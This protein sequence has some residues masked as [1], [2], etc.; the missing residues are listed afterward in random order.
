MVLLG[1]PTSLLIAAMLSGSAFAQEGF[2]ARTS[3]AKSEAIAACG[4]MAYVS[5]SYDNSLSVIDLNKAR[6]VVTIKTGKAP[7]N[8]TFNRDWTRLYV[9]NVQAGT[10]SIVDTKTRKVI[11]TISAGG[12]NPSG[13]RFLPDGKHLVIS[14]LGKRYDEGSQDPSSLGIMDLSTGKLI[15]EIALEVG[16]ERFDITPD[17]KKAYVANVRSQSILVIDLE[18]GE[19]I[20][21]IPS[22]EPAPFNVLV[23]PRGLRAYV[24][25]GTGSSIIEIDTANDKV[26]NI[27]RTAAGPNGMTFT[28]DG[29]NIL[30]T[31][32]YAGRMQAYNL[33]TKVVNEGK[34]VGLFP[35]HLRL[36][37]DGTKGVFVRPYGR[38]VGIFDGT[39]M[40]VIKDIAT[41]SGPTTVAICGNP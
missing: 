38:T 17:G 19:V 18:K 26:I 24:A 20:A 32:T 33:T 7:V 34:S 10:I 9:S 37:P 5:N 6:L 12:T 14:Y 30:F 16:A 13:L 31:A 25:N 8:P 21:R 36:T 40:D 35:G 27:V 23:S 15:K 1:S 39:N 22:P 4:H 2:G 11:D 28:P 29:D 41:G 3:T